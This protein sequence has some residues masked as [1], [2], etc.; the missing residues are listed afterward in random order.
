MGDHVPAMNARAG[1]DVDN[2]I[3]GANG[4]FIVLHHNHC[5]TDVTQM[6][7]GIE[8]SLVIALV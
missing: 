7:Q 4:F 3:G 5:I 2:V 1:A 8:E 6:R